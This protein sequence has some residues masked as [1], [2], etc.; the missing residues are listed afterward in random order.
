MLHLPMFS[1]YEGLT[2]DGPQRQL[3]GFDYFR[4]FQVVK[5]AYCN[6]FM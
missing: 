1:E 5:T 4:L 3:I 6:F 2:P